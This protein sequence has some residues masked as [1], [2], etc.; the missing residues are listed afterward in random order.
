MTRSYISRV[1]RFA[2]S[3][4]GYLHLGHG[5][6]ALLNHEMALATGGKLLLRIEDIDLERCR[7]E[8]EQAIYEDLAWLGLKWQQPVRRQSEHFDAYREA[9]ASLEKRGLVYPCFC[10]R[11]DVVAATSERADWPRDPDD[12][13][14]YPGTCRHLAPAER[15]RRLD[16]GQPAAW[17]LDMARALEDVRQP[18]D[19]REY[20]GGSEPRLAT[21]QPALWGDTILSRKDV[22]ASYHIAVVV[23]DALQG[24]TDVVRGEDLF[25]AT[26]LHRLLQILLDLPAPDYHHHELLRDAAGRKLSKS[27]R[28]KSLRTLRQEGLT[29]AKLKTQLGLNKRSFAFVP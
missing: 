22:P 19:W 3:P 21:A 5:F 13:P 28:A 16:A 25:M 20:G 17:R 26:G 24:V 6:S 2:P 7:P 1:F 12:L 27:L 4:N 10:S 14:L 11:A 29:P 15:R 8:F 18:I 9:L 23:D